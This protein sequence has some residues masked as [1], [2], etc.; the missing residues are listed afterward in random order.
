MKIHF[1]GAAHTVTGSMHRVEVNGLNLLLDCGLFQGKRKEAFQRNRNFSFDPAAIDAC[2]LS[3][4]H[5]DHSGNLPSLVKAGFKGPIYATPAT[6]ELC[7]FMLKDSAHIQNRDV[8]YVNKRRKRQGQTLHEPLYEMKDVEACLKKMKSHRYHDSFS[9]GPGVTCTFTDAGHIL[10]SAAVTL[11]IEENGATRRLVFTGDVGREDAPIINDPE[12]VHDVDFVITEGTYGDRLHPA[13]QDIKTKL[14]ELCGAIVDKKSRLLIPAFAVGRTQ[15]I[16]YALNELHAEGKLCPVPV[17]VDSPMAT[18]ATETYENH[19]QNYDQEALE[20]LS[21]GDYPFSFPKLRFTPDVEASKELSKMKG[22]LIIISASGMCEGGRI[23]HHLAQGVGNRDNIILFP[24]F[25]AQHTLGRQLIEKRNP[26]RIFGE[27]FAV[28]AQIVSIRGLSAHA[29]QKG[30]L[31]YIGAMGKKLKQAFVVHCEPH[32]G[33]TLA[34]EIVNLGVPKAE[35]P[36][37]NQSF[38]I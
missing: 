10:G 16:L 20:Y 28:R 36:T 26:V 25:Q 12:P 34:R 24:G 33:R 6:I 17:F 35:V 32:P 18:T 15:Q 21:K 3:H 8:L 14:K 2:I 27:E 7:S 19:A 5:I 38:T 23:L 9:P 30:L 4:A 11:D 13:M 31:K 22:P 29:D 1:H 37:R